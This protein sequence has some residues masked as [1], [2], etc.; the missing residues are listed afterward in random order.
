VQKVNGV[1]PTSP[2]R[3]G[4]KIDNGGRE[5]F[6]ISIK[7]AAALTAESEWTVKQNLAAGIYEACKSGR[8]TLIVYESV[9][10]HVASLPRQNLPRHHG[11]KLRPRK[12]GRA[13]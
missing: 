8:R 10:R 13:L 2:E 12:K 4:R 1:M 11:E 3:T 6:F 9:K 5:P 7:D